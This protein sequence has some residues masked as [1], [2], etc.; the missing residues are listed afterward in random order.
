MTDRLG[1]PIDAFD[2]PAKPGP[3]AG[4]QFRDGRRDGRLCRLRRET[5]AVVYWS[6]GVIEI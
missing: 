5:R 6:V 3:R 2:A 4:R 1:A